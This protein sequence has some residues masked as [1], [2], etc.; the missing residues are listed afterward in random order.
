MDSFYDTKT[1]WKKLYQ[2]GELNRL[3][4]NFPYVDA[5]LHRMLVATTV[6]KD[7]D[8]GVLLVGFCDVDARDCKTRPVLP[9]PYVSDICV[10]PDYRRKGIAQALIQ[11]SERFLQKIPR[12][13]VYI[14]VEESN[15]AA[16]AM[17]EK[18]RYT[19]TGREEADPSKKD[20]KTILVLQKEFH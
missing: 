16:I 13:N 3:Q 17:Y 8:R 9:R 12:S 18:L 7:D 1:S 15:H 19:K 4:Q 14:R 2:L 6:D 5:D 20:S 10:H 11:E